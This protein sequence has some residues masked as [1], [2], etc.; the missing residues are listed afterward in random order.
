MRT[1]M[2]IGF[3][4]VAAL[5]AAGANATLYTWDTT[6]ST[7]GTTA[8]NA[9]TFTSGGQTITAKA[10]ETS[11]SFAPNGILIGTGTIAGYTSATSA[12]DASGINTVVTSAWQKAVISNYTGG[13]G[14]SLSPN[15]PATTPQHAIDNNGAVDAVVFD[16]GAGK[17]ADW[18]SF[19]LG[20]SQVDSDVQA[21]VGNNSP[22]GAGDFTG[23]CFVAGCASGNSLAS[24]GF[25]ETANSANAAS[26][27]SPNLK[28]V[29]LNTTEALNS[30][31][32]TGR[33][34]IMSG[35]L[36]LN[37]VS[38][39]NDFFK[40]SS[41]SVTGGL[42]IAPE[43]GSIALLGLGLAALGFSRRRAQLRVARSQ[44]ISE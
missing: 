27:T 15:D 40:I 28:D 24:L 43:P 19:M 20:W 10:Y 18:T 34:L 5:M 38:T 11:G 26:N 8:G 9:L 44:Q 41:I 21:W 12:A 36:G 7:S 14:V 3:A 1:L 22:G 13:I 6:G 29:A 39:G 17:V 31:N 42:H 37:G 23:V 32:L 30:T 4:V 35:D 16:A 2:M 33:Y 25:A